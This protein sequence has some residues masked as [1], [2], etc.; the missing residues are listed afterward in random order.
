MVV[1]PGSHLFP[2]PDD[3]PDDVAVMAELMAVTVGLDR[4]RSWSV[5]PSEPFLVDDTVVVYGAGPLGLCHVIKARLLGAGTII[6]IAR[7][8]ERLSFARELG[9]DVT[10]DVRETTEE[11]RLT[12]VRELTGG[13]G[14]DVVVEAAGVPEVVPPA[15]DLLRPGGLLIE[16]GNFS[17][18]GEV[19]ISPHRHL[20]SKGIRLMGV[21]GEEPG[22]YLPAMRQLARH[23]SAIPAIDRFVSDRCSLDDPDAAMRRSIDPSS[24]KV[25]FAP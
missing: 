10:L 22:A 14:A 21:A 5:L 20:C 25:V 13:R 6:A 17:N 3:L 24:R 4:A 19:M 11:E 16:V 8:P 7:S 9:A 2:V 23:R 1:L 15:I 18:G 12:R